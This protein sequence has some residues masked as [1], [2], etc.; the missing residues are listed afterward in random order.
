MPPKRK[1]TAFLRLNEQELR[2]LSDIFG[3]GYQAGH[4]DNRLEDRISEKLA[5]AL[6]RLQDR[7]KGD[8]P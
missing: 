4:P 8:A 6:T 3:Q 2:T 7:D 5:R 1:P